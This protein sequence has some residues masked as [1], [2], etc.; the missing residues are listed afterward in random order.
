MAIHERNLATNAQYLYSP[1]RKGSAK[2]SSPLILQYAAV[3][4]R[5]HGLQEKPLENTKNVEPQTKSF[6]KA[7]AHF[8]TLEPDSKTPGIA[9]LKL[10]WA[11]FLISDKESE[12]LSKQY[13]EQVNFLGQWAAGDEKL[14]KWT[15]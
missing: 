9:L 7:V 8:Q 14:F 10:L 6:Q 2:L 4:I 11:R 12:L 15:G 1:S 3:L 13:A 5:I